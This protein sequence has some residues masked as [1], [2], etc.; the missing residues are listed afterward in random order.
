MK[1]LRF[2]LCV[3]SLESARIAE[4]GGADRIE[5]CSKLWIGGVT[6]PL[7]LIADCVRLLTIPVRVLIRPRGGD[8]CYAAEE[9]DRMRRQIEEA[10]QAGAAGIAVGV[11]LPDGR[12]DLARSRELVELARPMGVTF[13]RAFDETPQMD[14]AL[15]DVI[16]TGA[17][18]LLTSGGAA[19][20]VAGAE[21]IAR[22]HRLAGRRL[23][24]MAGGGLRLDNLMDVVR[25]TGVT[26]LH[27]SLIRRDARSGSSLP[28]NGD[29]APV[30]EADV[31]EAVLLF[32]QAHRALDGEASTAG[33][34]KDR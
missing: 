25:R 16:A 20:V 3:E 31:R 28:R 14:E 17:D 32:H 24:V 30:L 4:A 13:H 23:D 21:A 19:D 34:S 33:G 26:S 5:L 18:C 22:L 15:E 2:E 29:R 11:L 1:T 8:F 10:K 27:G 9:F 7:D 6:P 12:V